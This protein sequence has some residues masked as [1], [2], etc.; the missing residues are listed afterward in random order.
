MFYLR[1]KFRFS[2][3]QNEIEDLYIKREITNFSHAKQATSRFFFSINIIDKI[4]SLFG[5]RFFAPL[6]KFYLFLNGTHV[7]LAKIRLITY[8]DFGGTEILIET[9]YAIRFAVGS[10]KSTENTLHNL[11]AKKVDFLLLNIISTQ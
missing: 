7:K 2:Y 4:Y 9:F 8:W 6:L 11:E 3:T 5:I 10:K 1:D